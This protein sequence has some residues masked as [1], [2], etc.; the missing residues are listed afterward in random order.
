MQKYIKYRY[1]CFTYSSSDNCWWPERIS[2]V[3][4]WKIDLYVLI[5]NN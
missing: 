1:F 3:Y 2:Y 5:L 4:L